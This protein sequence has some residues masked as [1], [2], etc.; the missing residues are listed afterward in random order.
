MRDASDAV[1]P[2][3][4][5]VLTQM[6]TGVQFITVTDNGG[7]YLFAQLK[8]AYYSIT[9]SKAGFKSTTIS[10]I[11]LLLGQR[12]RVDAV[13]RVGAVTQTVNVS[14]GG[15][16]LLETQ[17]SSAGMVI[18]QRPIVELPLN[19]RNFMQ[20]TVLAPTVSP[21][22]GGNSVV[23]NWT[24]MSS[25]NGSTS[26]A[27]M[28]EANISYLLDGIE[29]R[30]A[31]FGS[32]D[33]HPSVDA[34]Q[35]FRMQTDA[36]SAE[37]GRSSAIVN[38]TLKSGTNQFH[39]DA[40][41]F[42]RN[43]ALDA[44]DFF[45]NS[46][47]LAI[48]HYAQNDFGATL[49]GPIRHDKTF[50]FLSYE[51]FRSRTGAAG[52]ALVM[53]PAQWKG[54]LADNSAGTG[55]FPTNSA[56]CQS[57]PG[58]ARCIDIVNPFSGQA[59]PGN[60]IPSNLLDPRA[61]E[62]QAFSPSPNIPSAVN[63]PTTPLFNYAATPDTRN[64][65]NDATIRLDDTLGA[66]DQLYGSYSFHDVPHIIQS[67]MPLAGKS[68]PMRSQIVSLTESHIFSPTIVNEARFGYNRGTTF[69]VSQGA[70]G[71]NYAATVFGLT[72]TSTNSFDFGVPNA[73]MSGF[74]TIGSP[75]ESIGSIDQDF[76]W[77]DNLSIAHGGHNLKTGMD[78]M[79][80]RFF[81]ITDFSG[82]P[83]FRFTGQFSGSPLS[84]MLLGIP[85]TA[86]TAVGNSAQHLR[87]TY[88]AGYVQDDWRALSNLTL[89]MGIRYEYANPPYDTK[90][91]TAWFNPA[92]GQLQYSD[93]GD[94]RNGIVDP[95]YK[96][97]A[98]RLGFAYSPAFSHG[99]VI[100]GAF[101]V[102]YATESWNTMQFMV[103]APRY[104]SAQTL[105][106]DPVTPTLSLQNLFPPLSGASTTA[107]PFSRYDHARTPY[108][109]EWNY[110]VQHMFGRNWMADIGYVGNRG[111]HLT[112][113]R[114]LD[115]APFD[116]TG[117]IP[118]VQRE[119]W[120]NFSGILLEDDGGFSTYNALAARL[121]KRTS[122]GLYFLGSYTYS[123]CL[124][125]TSY[126]G[127]QSYAGQD[128]NV[129]NYGQCTWNVPQRAVFSYVYE[130]PFGR[131][132]RFF[133]NMSGV[134]DK[135][136]SGWEVTG[137]TTFAMG[138]FMTVTLP[139]NWMNIGPFTTAVPN[140]VGPAYPSNR[141]L[142]NWLNID[143]FVYPG[144]PSATPC[145]QGL[146]IEGNSGRNQI[147]V[148]GVNNW[149]MGLMKQ[150]QFSERVSAQFRAEFF[151]TWNHPQF[152]SPSGS[153]VPG[154]FGRIHGLLIPAR[155][156]Q[157]GLKLFF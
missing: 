43:S 11:D 111:N 113:R 144:C 101:G 77:V 27:G 98:P 78:I 72:N 150:I 135:L 136:F 7:N 138:Q 131:G 84:E 34:L 61:Q 102:F 95:D 67:V 149:D 24:G 32:E 137:I 25:G 123:H 49:G 139:G 14:A 70:L 80:E 36:F 69:L 75:S 118:L 41:E 59:F 152:D 116:P 155:E 74:T 81:E 47:G 153:L 90:N 9:V 92:I 85:D 86:G 125:L 97:V 132:R 22:L 63:S 105:T 39:G 5:V 12:P 44:N 117:T 30:N 4:K 134:A 89:N 13:L 38:M 151:N 56:F 65:F 119:P 46:E 62:W 73:V 55:I 82:V 54:D 143:S 100:R 76:Q 35:E 99:T 10:N 50:F 1:V 8:P 146:H 16:Q 20:L 133:A 2:D 17:T 142:N 23:A 154:T 57:N 29:T 79:R 66:K 6:A 104:Y 15:V 93:L 21:I 68:F 145:A 71:P 108:V 51:G 64:D 147:E 19:G 53:S 94:V 83:S 114:N 156:I 52:Q 88:Y 115:A 87:S 110:D 60:V 130:L 91:R 58:S 141:T 37:Y 124:N 127:E 26:V 109:L 128:T 120:P 126:E 33:L 107:L 42:V 121:E 106:S 103:N 112:M 28:D 40:F 18:Q 48:P 122:A 96:N 148:P 157:F 129:Y 45:F 140:K 31:R 3:V